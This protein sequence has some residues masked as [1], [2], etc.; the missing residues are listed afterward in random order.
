MSTFQFTKQ[1]VQIAMDEWRL[2]W[3]S[4]GTWLL[5]L[6]LL[7]V[8]ISEHPAF[9]VFGE[10]SLPE[11]ASFWADRVTI[12]GSLVAILTV[13]FALDRVRRQRMT[14][15]ELTKPFD[16]L[17]YVL[18][19]FAGATLPLFTLTAV[20]LFIHLMITLLTKRPPLAGSVVTY[21]GQAILVNFV[22]LLFFTSLTYCMSVFIRRPIIIIPIG[23][24]YMILTTAT[25][26]SADA[27]FSWFSAVV[28]PEYFGGI[29]PESLMSTV[30]THH[31]I[32]LGLSV[33]LLTLTVIGF[34]RGRFTNDSPTIE[35]WKRIR[36]PSFPFIDMRFR[37][38]WNGYII[39]ALLMALV[40]IAN[41]MSNP[42]EF[43]RVEYAFFGLEFY[44]SLSGLLILS[45]VL[46]RDKAAGALDLVLTKPVNRWRLLAERLL[47]AL[48]LF[49]LICIAS[50][51]LLNVLYE[52]LP[53]AKSL[54]IALSTG[55]YLGMLGMT[56]ANITRHILAGIGAGIAYW[57]FEAGFNGQFT[58]PFYLLIVSHQIP[59]QAGEVWLNPAIWLPIKTGTLVLAALFFLVNGWLLDKDPKRRHAL[60][61]I[62]IGYPLVYIL[63][64]WLVPIFAG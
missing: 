48:T 38:L 31:A 27:Q 42:N 58:A 40:A 19:K 61:A 10:F 6:F 1:S 11:A 23:L 20:S 33:L 14:P 41:T 3:R 22:P 56:V 63:G 17:A 2:Q 62:L 59:P 7:A 52:P 53:I 28:R 45:G 50:V 60:A 9:S 37:M 57:F 35:W 30:L 24:T 21:L 54:F 25:Q 51:F 39:A 55:I 13:P 36:L 43:L 64:W 12:V 4:W 5:G 32:Y 18:G 8:V 47:P 46:V 34:R 29:I 16:R 26:A 44:L 15:I 49:V